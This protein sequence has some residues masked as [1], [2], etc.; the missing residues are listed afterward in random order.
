MVWDKR[1]VCKFPIPE[2][3]RVLELGCGTG[4]LLA[5]LTPSYG[6]GVDLSAGMIS[7]A[8]K[9]Y[10]HLSFICDDIEDP[11]FISSLSGPFDFILIVDTIGALVRPH[12]TISAAYSRRKRD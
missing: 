2:G 10:P 3:S 7:Q 4:H 8:Q 6:V 9:A 11:S 5:G 1:Q 12:S